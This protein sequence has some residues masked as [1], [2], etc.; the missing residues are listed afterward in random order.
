MAT[1]VQIDICCNID[2]GSG[3]AYIGQ[4]KASF[5]GRNYKRSAKV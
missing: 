1:Y 5:S 2:E 3:Y 4:Y